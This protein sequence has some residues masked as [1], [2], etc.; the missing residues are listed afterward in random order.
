MMKRL[1]ADSDS[2]FWLYKRKSGS[3]KKEPAKGTFIIGGEKIPFNAWI[4]NK[5]ETIHVTT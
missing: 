4:S 3:L 5:G 1:C 2:G